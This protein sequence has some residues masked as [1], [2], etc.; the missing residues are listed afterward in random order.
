MVTIVLT[1]E[2][3]REKGSLLPTQGKDTPASLTAMG[4]LSGDAPERP[5]LLHCPELE[6]GDGNEEPLAA[7]V[8]GGPLLSN[9]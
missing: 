1:R 4:S 9:K 8:R 5:P 2:W 6:E 3:T 7:G